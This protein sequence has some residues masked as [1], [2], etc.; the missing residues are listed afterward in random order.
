MKRPGHL[1]YINPRATGSVFKHTRR[2]GVPLIR[3]QF[4]WISSTTLF[5]V[6]LGIAIYSNQVLV[7]AAEKQVPIIQE[8]AVPEK[9]AYTGAYVD[10][11]EGEDDVTL[12]AI[13]RF[14]KSFCPPP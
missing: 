8:L 10:F 14:E 11:G 2:T 6:L 1:Q 7:H 12:E 13:E 5:I 9:G 4:M 3:L